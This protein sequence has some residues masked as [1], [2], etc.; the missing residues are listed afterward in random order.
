MAKKG[1]LV[2]CYEGAVDPAL[3]AEYAKVA[4]PAI[5]AGGGRLLAA[6]QPAKTYESGVNHRVVIFEFDSVEQAIAAFESDAYK[7]A[8]KVFNNA[9]PRDVR[10]VEAF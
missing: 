7:V 10:I 9:T 8:F 6:G 1:Y 4:R 3:H 5:A 2:V